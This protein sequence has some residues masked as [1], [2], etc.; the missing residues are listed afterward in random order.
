MKKIGKG[1]IHQ[2]KSG[3]WRAEI[4]IGRKANGRK[5]MKY[6]YGDTEEEASEQLEDF[7]YEYKHGL[8]QEP[9][10]TKFKEWI[11]KWLKRKE[12]NCVEGSDTLR[13]YK[14]FI[15]NRIIPT[16]GL[17]ELE[18]LESFRIEEKLY[19]WKE[20]GLGRNSINTIYTILNQSLK[21]AT[22]HKKIKSNPMNTVDKPKF[23]TQ[24]N[25]FKTLSKSEVNKFLKTVKEE[26]PEYYS[27]FFIALNTG[28][29][30]GEVLGLKWEDI[31]FKDRKI[32]I[33]RQLTGEKE[34]KLPKG[35]KKREFKVPDKVINF[36]RDHKKEQ[37][38]W[39]LKLGK[40]YNNLDLINC[41]KDG[42]KLTP[43][44][45][46]GAII[47]RLLKKAKV[48]DIRFHEL[49]HTFA[50]L[51]IQGGIEPKTVQ[52]ILGHSKIEMT[53]NKYVDVNDEMLD[54]AVEIMEQIY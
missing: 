46:S 39:R 13:T 50:T 15:D 54:Q 11:E 31:N 9:S 45:I 1:S 48:T 23:R 47:K 10:K 41:K 25:N 14:S 2:L 43:N 22:K 35:E 42:S 19:D 8:Y 28:M 4:M 38:K 44:Y 5:D 52:Q 6:F 36:L 17:Y 53:L 32:K 40:E 26:A 33:Q 21:Y 51:C 49:R 18:D 20:E 30:R 7:R 29:R 16:F 27:V 3:R 34:F 24:K 37:N 12:K